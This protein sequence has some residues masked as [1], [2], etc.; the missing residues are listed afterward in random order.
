MTYLTYSIVLVF[1]RN[2]PTKNGS[3]MG[4][5]L[6][7]IE[8]QRKMEVESNFN[9]TLTAHWTLMHFGHIHLVNYRKMASSKT[10]HLEA[11]AGFFQISVKTFKFTKLT[12]IFK[13]INQICCLLMSLRNFKN[14]SV[15]TALCRNVR[16]WKL[17]LDQLSYCSLGFLLFKS[18]IAHCFFTRLNPKKRNFLV[19]PSSIA[20]NS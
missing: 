7:E 10:S 11:L 18:Y 20:R 1:R 12:W 16:K 19:L 6:R 5:F 17:D 14:A 8:D 2:N 15:C 9:L 13:S 3:K 4:V